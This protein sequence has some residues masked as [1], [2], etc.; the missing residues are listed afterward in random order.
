[1]D[2]SYSKEEEITV[3]V[4]LPWHSIGSF[5]QGKYINSASL[6][7][8]ISKSL[9]FRKGGMEGNEA[10]LKNSAFYSHLSCHVPSDTG[11]VTKPIQA[12]VTYL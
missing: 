7:V 4:Y 9:R 11:Q 12:S 1:M 6:P 5:F 2:F 8:I 10:R 3:G